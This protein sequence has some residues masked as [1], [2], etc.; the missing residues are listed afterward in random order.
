MARSPQDFAAAVA[1]SVAVMQPPRNRPGARRAMDPKRGG[2]KQADAQ[3]LNGCLRRICSWRVPP[4]WSAHDWFGEM[5]IDAAAALWQA[6]C[7][8]DA[9]RGVPL[10]AFERLR[11]LATARTRYRQEWNYAL[12]CPV[13]LDP[14]NMDRQGKSPSVS[15]QIV[16]PVREVLTHIPEADQWLLRQLFWAENSE[17]VVARKLGVSQQA[18]SKRKRVVLRKLFRLLSDA[19]GEGRRRRASKLIRAAML[20]SMLWLLPECLFQQTANHWL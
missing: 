11:V 2:G 13:G 6:K 18:I 9:S 5:W 8:Y 4:N 16:S 12:H 15:R 3:L 20:H 14:E 17:A 1:E 19:R 7:D 10:T